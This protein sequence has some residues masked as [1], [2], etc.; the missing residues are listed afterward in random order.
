MTCFYVWC[1]ICD[2][3]E[4]KE[5]TDDNWLHNLKFNWNTLEIAGESASGI[6][7]GCFCVSRM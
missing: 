3:C 4:G 7:G 5:A 6:F 2:N 1:E